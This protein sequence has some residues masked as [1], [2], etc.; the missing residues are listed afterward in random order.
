[1]TPNN[2][3]NI[4]VATTLT[5]GITVGAL[6]MTVADATGYPAAPFQVVLDLGSATDEEAVLIT[7]KAG[8]TWTITRAYDGTTAKAHSSGVSVTHTA[9]ARDFRGLVLGT[10]DMATTA[11]ADGNAVVWNDDMVVWEPS[12]GLT[13]T[14]RQLV[15][16]GDTD[17]ATPLLIGRAGDFHAE[18]TTQTGVP[19][20]DLV[21]TAVAVGATGNDITVSYSALGASQPLTIDVTGSAI[22]VN[23]ATDGGSV[24]TSTA[25]D[26]L[27]AL[28][29]DVNA[30]ALITTTL[31][32]GNDGSG[33]LSAGIF[34]QLAGG[35]TVADAVWIDE[36]GVI[37]V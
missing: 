13:Y 23:M 37:N 18:A 31:A 27:A 17:K 21:F 14:D 33:V 24:V 26:V 15:V 36:R 8:T 29:A 12:A 3:S 11:P 10:R 22:T 6:S 1:M 7:V 19:D 32:P 16:S 35:A 2:F 5:A 20:G 34:T 30:S 25:S 4:S 28:N 9:L